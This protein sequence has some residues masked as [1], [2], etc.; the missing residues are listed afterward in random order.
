MIVFSTPLPTF[1]ELSSLYSPDSPFFRGF[2]VFRSDTF[3]ISLAFCWLVISKKN[4]DL[5]II[6]HRFTG[7]K[8]EIKFIYNN[9]TYSFKTSLIGEIQIINLFMA[10]VAANKSNLS[11][12]KIL[13]VKILYYL[14]ILLTIYILLLA[15]DLI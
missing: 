2:N 9:R 10:I 15:K 7:N 1:V 13:F 4:S 8:Q 12:Q 6:N 11:M 14:A 3:K 5:R